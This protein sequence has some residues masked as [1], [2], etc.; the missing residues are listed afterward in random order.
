MAGHSAL[1]AVFF[2]T[3]RSRKEAGQWKWP[4]L[5]PVAM[6]LLGIT[7]A[8]MA[9]GVVVALGEYYGMW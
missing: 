3:L 9:T 6:T 7:F 8:L 5:Y 4:W 2:F 1:L